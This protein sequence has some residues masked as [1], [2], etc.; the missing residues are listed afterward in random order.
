MP[1]LGSDSGVTSTTMRTRSL[2]AGDG[3][4]EWLGAEVREPGDALSH[5][6]YA[7]LVPGYN[8]VLRQDDA[9]GDRVA[10]RNGVR[11]SRASQLN[12]IRTAAHELRTNHDNAGRIRE[13]SSGR[14]VAS[15]VVRH[16]QPHDD[17]VA[18]VVP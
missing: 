18:P 10:R 14:P 12:V 15:A 4:Q 2:A 1:V 5:E 6:I 16:R 9:D 13:S 7:H 11:E 3:Q 17:V 8:R